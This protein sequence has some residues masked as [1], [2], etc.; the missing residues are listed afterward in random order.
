MTEFNLHNKK[1]IKNDLIEIV[2]NYNILHFDEFP[3]LYIGTNKYGN[4]IIGSHLDED[5]ESKTILSIHTILTSKEYHQFMNGKI[6][7]LNIL[8]NSNS[9]C[10]VEKDY[11][12]NIVKAYDIDFNSIPVEYL[13][14]EQSFC[15]VTVKAHS[16]VYSLSLKGKLADLNKAIAD[17]VSKIQNCFTEFLEERINSLKGFNLQPMA[18]LQPYADGSFKINFELNLKQKKG[19]SGNLFLELAPIDK[20][21]ADF[22]KYISDNFS[23]D[24]DIFKNNVTEYSEKF[25]QLESSLNEIYDKAFINKP[26]NIEN[27]LKDDIIKSVIKFEKITEQVGEHFENVSISNL[28]NTGETS[29]AFIGKEYSEN[30]QKNVEEIEIAKLG[31]TVDENYRDYKIYIY[32]LNTDTRSGNAFIK[33]LDNDEIMSKP[34][35]KINGDTALEQTKYAE[36]L[37]LNKW[38][39]VK[40]KAKKVGEKFKQLDIEFEE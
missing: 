36:S 27:F 4:K 16:L 25:K 8:Q 31:L 24:I 18:M 35:I 13:P 7:Y 39:N 11:N 40:A 15:P 2:F 3:I 20:Y 9:I 5:D 28:F 33:N 30:F 17:E 22:I 37:Y 12:F 29:L 38:I 32:H 21:M 6:S 19:K 14:L 23:D 26:D 34:K 10:I 1:V